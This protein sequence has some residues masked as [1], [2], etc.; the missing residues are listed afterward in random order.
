MGGGG[1]GGGEKLK[2]TLAIPLWSYLWLDLTCTPEVGEEFPPAHVGE[3]HVEEAAVL[4]APAQVHQERVVDLLVPRGGG[5]LTN[6]PVGK[7]LVQDAVDR[8]KCGAN[9]IQ[10]LLCPNSKHS[11]SMYKIVHYTLFRIHIPWIRIRI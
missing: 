11:K 5:T 4:V 7:M 3:H 10:C 6:R 2:S 9:G 8:G 1:G